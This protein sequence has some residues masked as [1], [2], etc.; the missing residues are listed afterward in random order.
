M[1]PGQVEDVFG[2]LVGGGRARSDLCAD[3]V[4]HFT[5]RFGSAELSTTFES[6]LELSPRVRKCHNDTAPLRATNLDPDG[7]TDEA[8]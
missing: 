3:G 5:S 7:K 6:P 8:R 2:P 4:S 1:F